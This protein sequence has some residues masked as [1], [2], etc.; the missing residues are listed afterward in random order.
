MRDD[1]VNLLFVFNPFRFVSLL[2][3]FIHGFYTWLI[4]FNTFRVRGSKKYSF[5]ADSCTPT[6]RINYAL[7]TVN[8]HLCIMNRALFF[9]IS[10]CFKRISG[11]CTMHSS[12]RKG[13]SE[14]CTVQSSLWKRISEVCT[15]QSSLRKRI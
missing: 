12:L 15:V 3:Y 5:I 7:S 13:I 9:C 4:T 2:N 11:F 14:V 8:Y 1:F 10:V 6:E